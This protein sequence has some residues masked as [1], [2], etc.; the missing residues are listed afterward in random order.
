MISMMIEDCLDH[1]G[2][3][4]VAVAS[5]LD[6]GL[7]KARTLDI[8]VAVLD[9]N[10]HGKLSYP[11]AEM[12]VDRHI[13][14]IF[15]TGYGRAGLPENLRNVLVVTK[16]FREQQLADALRAATAGASTSGMDPLAR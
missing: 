3:D 2:Y 4:V 16:P 7:E 11:I 6:D 13:P 15:A 5:H 8:D 1:L 10:L 9:V 14:F 12:L